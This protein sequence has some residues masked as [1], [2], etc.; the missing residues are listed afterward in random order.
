MKSIDDINYFVLEGSKPII[1]KK[2]NSEFILFD[3]YDLEF[4]KMNKTGA[5][6][7]YLISQNVKYDEIKEFFIK[8]YNLEEEYFNKFFKKFID[9]FQLKRT[10]YCNLLKLDIID[11]I[12]NY[13]QFKKS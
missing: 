11:G 4:Y 7:M 1:F 13:E 2:E 6:I 10:I 9:N 8:K 5:E 3:A 12:N